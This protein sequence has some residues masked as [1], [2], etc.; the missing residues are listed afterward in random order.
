[1][2]VSVR[3]NKTVCYIDRVK[4]AGCLVLSQAHTHTGPSRKIKIQNANRLYWDSTKAYSTT[5][6]LIIWLLCISSI[7]WFLIFLV[8]NSSL[9]LSLSFVHISYAKIIYIYLFTFIHHFSTYSSFGTHCARGRTRAHLLNFS[10]WQKPE[11]SSG[12][13]SILGKSNTHPTSMWD[14]LKRFNSFFFEEKN[15]KNKKWHD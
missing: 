13:E 4:C 11:D 6:S 2:L 10:V 7:R 9:S 1:M 5:K 3:S 15:A 12:Y 8:N 14:Y